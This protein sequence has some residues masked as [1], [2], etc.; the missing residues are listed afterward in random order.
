MYYTHDVDKAEQHTYTATVIPYR[1]AWLE[2]ETDLNNVFWVRIDKNRKL[3]ITSLI[4]ALGVDTDEKIKAMFGE[5]PRILATIEKDPKVTVGAGS[6]AC[7]VFVKF[8]KTNNLDNFITYTKAD[9]WTQLDGVTE[10]IYYRKV[11]TASSVQEF[12]VLNGNAVTVSNT[13]TKGMMEGLTSAQYPTLTFTASAIQSDYLN[14]G[15]AAT[16]QEKAL[17]AWITLNG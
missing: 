6:E 5:D 4:R 17:V 7:Y 8:E 13:V 2:Y 9:G 12:P 14:Y 1:G 10:E 16:E 11:G 15:T 3:P